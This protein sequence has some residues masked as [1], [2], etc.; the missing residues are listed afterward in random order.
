MLGRRHPPF[1]TNALVVFPCVI[2]L[3]FCALR[4]FR[5]HG[6]VECGAWVEATIY[7]LRVVAEDLPSPRLAWMER[8]VIVVWLLITRSSMQFNGLVARAAVAQWLHAMYIIAQ[9]ETGRQ[10]RGRRKT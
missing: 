7:V 2:G 10:R 1:L 4:G 5:R 9:H 8:Q 3:R 6:V